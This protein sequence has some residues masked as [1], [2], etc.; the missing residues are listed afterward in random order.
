MSKAG[1]KVGPRRRLRTP[2]S[3]V[4]CQSGVSGWPRR[5]S[6]SGATQD[7][8]PSAS[9]STGLQPLRSPWNRRSKIALGA[10]IVK[11]PSQAFTT[12]QKEVG[13]Y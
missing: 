7:A 10:Y 4:W 3:P 6:V 11:P 12:L 8:V 5:Q 2:H 9:F 1:T 13:I